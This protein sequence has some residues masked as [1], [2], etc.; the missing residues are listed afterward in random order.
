VAAKATTRRCSSQ[1]TSPLRRES[2]AYLPKDIRPISS[3][4][5]TWPVLPTAVFA[6]NAAFLFVNH[7]E[8]KGR[9]RS[10]SAT[11]NGSVRLVRAETFVL[12]ESISYTYSYG[13]AAICSVLAPSVPQALASAPAEDCGTKCLSAQYLPARGSNA[14]LMLLDLIIGERF[15]RELGNK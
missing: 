15:R 9:G 7:P 3:R 8:R 6:T 1:R 13:S 11:N 4:R 2:A 10:F 12:K 14:D 5:S